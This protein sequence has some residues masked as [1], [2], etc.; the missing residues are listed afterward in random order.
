MASTTSATSRWTAT[1]E[2]DW[3]S[4]RMSKVGGA[5]R[6]SIA[7][8]V[9]RR[10]APSSLRGTGWGAPPRGG[11][12]GDVAVAGDLVRSVHDDDA[13]VH[14]VRQVAGDFAQHRRLANA[15]AAQEEHAL[16]IAHQVFDDAD[17]A[18]HGAAD[19]A[20]RPAKP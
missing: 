11:G 15:W 17:G 16:P 3:I 12:G 14:L 2:K 9:R 19:A 4:T 13:P 10:R 18:K 20:G 1:R 6:S 7:F 8:W 5:R